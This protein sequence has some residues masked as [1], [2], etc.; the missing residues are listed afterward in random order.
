MVEEELQQNTSIVTKRII[1]VPPATEIALKN[2]QKVPTN[3]LGADQHTDLTAK[4]TTIK[5][6]MD[7]TKAEDLLNLRL[8]EG[9][10]HKKSNA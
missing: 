1:G 10:F 8:E 3:K 2:P 7:Q 4:E 5:A 9:G 6:E